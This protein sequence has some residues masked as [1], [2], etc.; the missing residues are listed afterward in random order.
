MIC[1]RAAMFAFAVFTL[2]E[3][4]GAKGTGLVFVANEKSNTVTVLDAY[5]KAVRILPDVWTAP[6]HALLG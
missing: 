4:V 3:C 1:A 5:H 6:W 2:T